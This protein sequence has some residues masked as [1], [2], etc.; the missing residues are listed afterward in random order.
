MDTTRRRRSNE[1]SP[2]ERRRRS[3]DGLLGASFLSVCETDIFSHTGPSSLYVLLLSFP[4]LMHF[5]ALGN[6]SEREL[7]GFGI[8]VVWRL[9]YLTL[10]FFL[11]SFFDSSRSLLPTLPYAL[12]VDDISFWG[13]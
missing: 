13:V 3:W 5:K 4:Y 6:W 12:C 8:G 7:E 10:I 2:D 9:P 1:E 11:F